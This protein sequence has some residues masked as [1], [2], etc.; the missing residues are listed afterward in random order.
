MLRL[1]APTSG[2]ADDTAALRAPRHRGRQYWV[3]QARADAGRRGARSAG[4]QRIRRGVDDS[5]PSTASAAALN[6]GGLGNVMCLDRSCAHGARGRGGEAFIAEV[7]L[8]RGADRRLDTSS[9][10]C[11]RSSGLRSGRDAGQARRRAHG[12]SRSRVVL[13]RHGDPAVAEAFLVASHGRPRARLRDAAASVDFGRIIERRSRGS[14]P[15]EGSRAMADRISRAVLITGCSTGSA[16][17][18]EHLAARGGPSTRPRGG[19]VDPRP[20]TRGCKTIASTCATRSR[21]ARGR[22]GRAREGAVGVLVNNAGYGQEGA[23]ERSRWP[24]CAASSRPNVSA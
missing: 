24:R 17:T 19:R 4:R 12:A 16:G 9:A 18:A 10:A 21:C 7:D 20:V 5:A 8:A 22:D 1:G 13:V 3:W 2:P 15:R 6:L 23:F 14:R 11:A